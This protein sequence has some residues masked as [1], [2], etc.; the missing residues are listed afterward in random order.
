MQGSSSSSSGR[1]G[2]GGGGGPAGFFSRVQ[3]QI[4]TAL[5]SQQ[6]GSAGSELPSFTSSS[7][8]FIRLPV[9]SARKLRLYDSPDAEAVAT[10]VREQ[11]LALKVIAEEHVRCVTPV[12]SPRASEVRAGAAQVRGGAEECWPSQ[13]S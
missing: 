12:R 6:P 13:D 1:G 9:S 11:T 5:T 10:L 4:Q 3:N 7:E 8:S 2:G